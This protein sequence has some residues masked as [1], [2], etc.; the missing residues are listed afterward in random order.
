[1]SFEIFV[2]TLASIIAGT[3]IICV[4]VV[5]VFWMIA[6][7]R[8]RRMLSHQE[9]QLLRETFEGLRKMEDRINN[10]ETILLE[11]EKKERERL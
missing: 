6:R 4:P 7:R 9:E 11:S 2:I 3:L 10:L 1:M 5:M 8:D